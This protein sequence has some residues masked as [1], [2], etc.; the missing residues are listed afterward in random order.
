[1]SFVLIKATPC[2]YFASYAWLAKT[3]VRPVNPHRRSYY[4]ID[5]LK[6]H[7]IIMKYDS[8]WK[9][10]KKNSEAMS[11]EPSTV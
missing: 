6:A 7:K 5:R 2:Y 3:V 1:M 8:G 10:K 4:N 11:H 9:V